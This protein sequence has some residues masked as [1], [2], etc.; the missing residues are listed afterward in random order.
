MSGYP[1]NG[2]PGNQGGYPGN[3]GGYPANSSAPPSYNQGYPGSAPP[4]NGY[5]GTQHGNIPIPGQS[6]VDPN[7][8][9]WFDAVD[10]DKNGQITATE[11]QAAL[12]NSDHS[13][14]REEAC[15][16]L[17]EMFDRKRSGSLNVNEFSEVFKYINQWKATF[18]GIDRDRNGYVEFN[19]LS[20]ALQQM[21][22]RFTPAF[23]QNLLI[24]YDHKTKRL[25]LDNFILACIHIK[26]LTDG[27]RVRDRNMQGQITIQYEDFIGLAM[28]IHQ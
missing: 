18:E 6:S 7:V 12:V 10:A 3:Q 26:R 20:Q 4:Q 15:R 24:K 21:G 13:H 8:S 11:L 22:Y 9:Q 27:F 19:E 14:F 1:G 28:G 5:T 2:Y 16:M 17:I 25:T 23:V